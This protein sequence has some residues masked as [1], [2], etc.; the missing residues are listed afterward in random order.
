VLSRIENPVGPEEM[1]GTVFL[2]HAFAP[3]SVTAGADQNRV[4]LFK[5]TAHNSRFVVLGGPGTG[6]TTLMKNL[7][8][9]IANGRCKEDLNELIPV[10]VVLRD[11]ASAGHTIEQAVIAVLASF[12]FKNSARFESLH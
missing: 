9:S 4:D 1:Q 8:L 10:F 2:D 5:F 12:R 6:K 7:V 3:I 11:M